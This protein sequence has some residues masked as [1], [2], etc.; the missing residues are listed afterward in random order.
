MSTT[1]PTAFPFLES[2]STFCPSCVHIMPLQTP[3]TPFLPS[4][5]TEE[6]LLLTTEP[7]FGDV[8][9]TLE[10]DDSEW[11][12]AG[13]SRLDTPNTVGRNKTLD[14]DAYLP[15]VEVT[16]DSED[17]NETIR[18]E[19][20]WIQGRSGIHKRG[21]SES[22]TR[23]R[24]SSGTKRGTASHVGLKFGLTIE[25]LDPHRSRCRWSSGTTS[26]PAD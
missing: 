16:D 2:L 1:P 23:E 9:I 11:P 18:I 13:P 17:G 12:V 14:L 7:F 25:Q 3:P 5:F 24:E 19:A 4:R 10:D 15:R 21:G 22:S 20:E 6:S 8:D 26:I